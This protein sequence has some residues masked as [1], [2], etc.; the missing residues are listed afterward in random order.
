MQK[1]TQFLIDMVMKE[2]GLHIKIFSIYEASLPSELIAALQDREK[3][4][5]VL[6]ILF[7]NRGVSA[8]TAFRLTTQ[9]LLFQNIPVAIF[10]NN[11]TLPRS[12]FR[13]PTNPNVVCFRTEPDRI[14]GERVGRYLI[15]KHRKNI[16]YLNTQPE[17]SWSQERFAGLSAYCREMGASCKEIILSYE[18]PGNDTFDYRLYPYMY[19]EV[20]H[21]DMSVKEIKTRRSL[22][23]HHH[24]FRMFT[25]RVFKFKSIVNEMEQK[26]NSNNIDA[27]VCCRDDL[28]VIC[29]DFLDTKGITIPGQIGVIGFDNT[30]E[31]A[32]WQLSSYEFNYSAIFRAMIQHVLG[33]EW[34][35]R[36][37]QKSGCVVIDG[38]VV[39][40]ESL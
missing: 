13:Q 16:V 19:H 21:I 24:N 31:S 40:R 9:Y 11:N 8:P 26:F 36:H 23:I 3:N 15:S 37:K 12:V 32:H 7:W 35:K 22:V 17:Q 5:S 14:S 10:D 29:T 6:G 27:I 1:E 30:V 39:E 4:Y 20:A 2:F 38:Y 28:S 34:I 33:H 25:E 18:H